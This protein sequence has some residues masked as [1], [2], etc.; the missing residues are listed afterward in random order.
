MCVRREPDE[1]K[2][3]KMQTGDSLWVLVWKNLLNFH[4]KNK[5]KRAMQH[6]AEVSAF[7]TRNRLKNG[8]LALLQTRFSH[9]FS[10]RA[11]S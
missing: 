3:G 11:G 10:L 4:L 2:C 7:I 8:T 5:A 9:S 6:I 1:E